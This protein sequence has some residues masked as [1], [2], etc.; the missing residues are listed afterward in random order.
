[1]ISGTGIDRP[2]S[3]PV[4]KK[5]WSSPN[6]VVLSLSRTETGTFIPGGENF[7]SFLAPCAPGQMTLGCS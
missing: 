6:V 5:V 2:N 3:D 1:M 4:T 7:I